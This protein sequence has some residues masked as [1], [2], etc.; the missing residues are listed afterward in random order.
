MPTS[1]LPASQVDGSLGRLAAPASAASATGR[2]LGQTVPAS[3]EE[4]VVLHDV[5]NVRGSPVLGS[6]KCLFLI[7]NSTAKYVWQPFI[8]CC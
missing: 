6:S 2:R 3:S 4:N 7:I 1:G 8:S 5:S